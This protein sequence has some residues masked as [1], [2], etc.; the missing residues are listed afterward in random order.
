MHLMQG[1]LADALD[2]G[3]EFVHDAFGLV[4]LDWQVEGAGRYSELA[5]PVVDAA[6]VSHALTGHTSLI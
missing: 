3:E 4:A 1:D 2:G 6:E 5:G